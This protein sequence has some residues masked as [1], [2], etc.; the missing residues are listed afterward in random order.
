MQ[1]HVKIL[2]GDGRLLHHTIV[3]EIKIK[4][5]LRRLLLL[6]MQLLMQLLLLLLLLFLIVKDGRAWLLSELVHDLLER[7]LLLGMVVHRVPADRCWRQGKK[8]CLKKKDCEKDDH[9]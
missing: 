7:R 3:R 1:D 9:C 8:F 4:H 6:L 2:L 5:V